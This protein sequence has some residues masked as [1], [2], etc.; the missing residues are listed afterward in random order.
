[1]GISMPGVFSGIDTET[2]ITQLMA[3]NRRPLNAL[4]IKKAKEQAKQAAV[5][6]LAG[7]LETLKSLVDKLRDANDLRT[8]LAT[9]S[10]TT[11]LTAVAG[12]GSSEGS[13]T[14]IVNQLATA[15]RRT[16]TAGLA[17]LD[18]TVG[19]TKSTAQNVNSV[20]D[21][22]ATWFTTSSNGATYTLDFGTETD[23]TGVTFAADTGYSMNQ[24]AAL[25]NARSQALA[26]YDAAAV[27]LDGGQYK[28]RLTAE[29][30]GPVGSLTQTLTAGDAVAE[31]NDNADWSKTTG[32][33][34]AFVYSYKGTTR[35][36]NT[37]PGTTLTNLRD[38]INNDAGNPGVTASILQYNG[39]Y[40]LVLGANDTGAG[41]EITINDALTTLAGFDSADIPETQAAQS[42]QIRVDGYPSGAWIERTSNSIADVITG[43]TLNLRSTGTVNVTLARNT[44]DLKQ[45][46]SNLVSIYNGLIDKIKDY[47]GYDEKTKKSGVMQGDGTM[48]TILGQVRSSLV[49]APGGFL[50]GQDAYTLAAQLGFQFDRYGKLSLDQTTLDDALSDNYLG[51]L[52]LLGAQGTGSSTSTYVQF[53]SAAE[54]TTAGTYEVAV[55]FDASGNITT[56]RIRGD[57]ELAWRYMNIDGSSLT[58]QSGNPDEGLHLTAVTDGT[59]GE[60]TQTATVR[61]RRGVAGAIYRYLDT[62]LD[63]TSGTIANKRSRLDTSIQNIDKNIATQEKRLEDQ[64]KRLRAEYARLEATLARFEMQRGAYE[65]LQ[66]Q[67]N[68]TNQ[69]SQK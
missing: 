19:Q 47:T 30:Y 10:D 53:A 5:N 44:A 57:G 26:G 25:I 41:N 29:E 34:G 50:G 31:L 64:E 66:Q 68:A 40:H 52:A 69:A 20:A 39:T 62:T 37:A 15:Q 55:D 7:R 2:I 21:A 14:I 23:I 61:A 12:A 49:S 13:H 8:A 18:T 59:P 33:A 17:G 45:D 38:L 3:I 42:A 36:I 4:S 35:T 46:L 58:G 16:H 24:V 28:L 56:A 63:A 22:D 67:L 1:M 11:V 65:A 48:S 6:D 51:V 32:L 27:E 54:D 9:S 43:V 60:H